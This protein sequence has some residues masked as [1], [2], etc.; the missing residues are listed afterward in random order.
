MLS[1]ITHACSSP[2]VEQKMMGTY[3]VAALFLRRFAKSKPLTLVI[4]TSRMKREN[5]GK[6][7][8]EIA[9]VVL[10]TTATMN[11]S[12]RKRSESLAQYS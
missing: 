1:P 6:S 5:D 7:H 9:S 10:L 8:E 2:M 3:S 4:A 12:R 11:P